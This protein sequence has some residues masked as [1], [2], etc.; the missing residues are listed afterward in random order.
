MEEREE[1]EEVQESKREGGRKRVSKGIRELTEKFERRE[2][3]G[4]NSQSD[5]RCEMGGEG[6]GGRNILSFQEVYSKFQNTNIKK[7]KVSV[8]K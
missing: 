5:R 1:G 8:S 7:G 3:E 2:E 6:P 4:H